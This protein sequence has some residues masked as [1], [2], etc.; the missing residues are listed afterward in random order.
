MTIKVFI[1]N[2]PLKGRSVQINKN[3]ASIGRGP[4][5]DVRINESSV[6]K[7]HAIIFKTPNGYSIEDLKS[8]NG[9][10]IDGSLISNGKK[11]AIES[12]IANFAWQCS[13]ECR[14]GSPIQF[15]FGSSLRS[16]LRNSLRSLTKNPSLDDTLMTNRRK[17]QQLFE[18]STAVDAVTRHKGKVYDKILDSLISSF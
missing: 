9:T 12:G 13:G 4:D 14:K 6:S 15:C 16:I 3:S 18:M 2:G 10:W 8:Q 11:I 5:N 17:L 7:R 1:H